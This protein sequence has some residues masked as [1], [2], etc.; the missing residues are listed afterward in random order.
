[1]KYLIHTR[2]YI[3]QFQMLFFKPILCMG[4]HFFKCSLI[5]KMSEDAKKRI[6][7]F[8]DFTWSSKKILEPY[9]VFSLKLL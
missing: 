7:L 1:M 8:I 9:W 3:Q 2:Q 6:N 5:L 4:K